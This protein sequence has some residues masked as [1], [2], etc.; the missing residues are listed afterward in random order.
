MRNWHFGATLLSKGTV[1]VLPSSHNEHVFMLPSL[2]QLPVA[3]TEG[4]VAPVFLVIA[5]PLSEA[6]GT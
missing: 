6:T 5:H 3:G 1:N 2:G 4:L